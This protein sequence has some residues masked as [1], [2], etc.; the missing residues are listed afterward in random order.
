MMDLKTLSKYPFLKETKKYVK[1]NKL[2]VIEIL[3]DPVYERA[4]VFGVERLENAFKNKD[5]GE[6]NPVTDTDCI[7]ELLSYPIAR[8]IAVCI[9]DLYFKRRYALGEAVHTYKNLIKEETSFILKVAKEFNLNVKYEDETEKISIFFIDYLKN[10]P[11]RYK[12]WKMINRSMEKGYIMIS[13]RNLARLLQENLRHRINEEIDNKKCNQV[14]LDTF[15]ED[16]NRI[17]NQVNIVRKKMEAEPVGKL[18]IKL[19]PPCMKN[20]LSSIQNGENVPHMGRFAIVSFLNTLGL[21]PDQILKIFSTAPDFEEEK[22]RYQ[23]EH[24]AGEGSTTSYKPPSCEKL[25]TYGLCPTEDM[26]KICKRTYHPLSYYRYNWKQNKTK[27][28]NEE[29]TKEK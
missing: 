22:S 29:K 23:V 14:I 3:S 9:G 25:K 12:N 26:D 16:I 5:V 28:K 10:A 18:E 11:T 21:N 1:E 6:R 20:I 24:I 13:K 8:M 19:L 15:K 2:S 7:M 17:R 4:R 27:K